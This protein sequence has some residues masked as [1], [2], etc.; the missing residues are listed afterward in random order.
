MAYSRLPFAVANLARA[1]LAGPWTPRSLVQRGQR[2]C[3]IQGNWIRQMVRWLLQ[4]FG[5]ATPPS[6]DTL[7]PFLVK[8]ISAA[9]FAHVLPIGK[10]YWLPET[11]RPRGPAAQLWNVPALTSMGQLAAWLDVSPQQL[12]WLADVRGWTVRSPSAKLRHYVCHW[13]PRR[14]GRFRLIESPKPHLKA[15]QRRLLH[16]ILDRI[17]PHPAVHG[18]RPGRSIL[19]YAG[20]HVGQRIVL[21]FDLR[22][23]FPSVRVFPHPRALP[24]CRLSR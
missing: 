11:M 22:D 13:Q 5:E 23:F 7:L 1:W 21:R 8:H 24:N 14:R 6:Y 3:P 10:L 12:D 9:R 19:T 18:F 20:P 15:V 2:A 16:E 17:P 4:N